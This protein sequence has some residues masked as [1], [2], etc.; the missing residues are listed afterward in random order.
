MQGRAGQI[1]SYPDKCPR[2]QEERNLIVPRN[3]LTRLRSPSC[4]GCSGAGRAPSDF[5]VLHTGSC[6]EV[7]QG[8]GQVEHTEVETCEELGG[9][10]YNF[11]S[12]CGTGSRSPPKE[13][14]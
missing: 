11:Y 8:Q 2:P 5:F 10:A 3:L 7:W 4:W 6:T 14:T 12:V 9:L 1:E 13:R